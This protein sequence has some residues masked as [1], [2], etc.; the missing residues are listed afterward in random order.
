MYAQEPCKGVDPANEH[1]VMGGGGEQWGET[2]D[3]SDIQQ[4]ELPAA[5]HTHYRPHTFP[6]VLPARGAPRLA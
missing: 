6:H 4:V 3:T 2:V 5:A 1:L